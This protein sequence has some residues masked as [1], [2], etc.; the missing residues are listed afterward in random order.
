MDE[1]KDYSKKTKNIIEKYRGEPGALIQAFQDV[2]T[3]FHYL[4]KEVIIQIAQNL[5]I[6]LSQAYHVATF[7]TAFSLKPRGKYL[8]NVCLGTACHVKQG[9]MILDSLGRNLNIEEGETSKDAKFTLESVRCLGCCSLAPVVKVDDEIYG[10]MN[11]SKA[12][13]LLKKY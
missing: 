13:R 8:I 3:E 6:P 12:K 7:Y 4:P 11:Q 1:I 5:D 2:Q 9:K 10:K